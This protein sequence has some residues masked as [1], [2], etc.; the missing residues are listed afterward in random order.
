[1]EALKDSKD[2]ADLPEI[3]RQ[4][5]DLRRQWKAVSV[6]P[7]DDA[8]TLWNR[9]KSAGDEVQ[10]RVDTHLSAVL[11]EQNA[12]LAK[13]L[14]LCEKAEALDAVDRLD[15]D[16]RDAEGAAGRVERDRAGAESAG[17]E[18]SVARRRAPLPHRVRHVLH[19]PQD[20]PRAA[21]ERVGAESAEER[22][23]LRAHGSAR[24]V[25][26]VG[27]DVQRDQ[28]APGRMEDGRS[29]AAQQVGSVVEAVP[30]RV[31]Q[32]LRALRQASRDRSAVARGGAGGDLPL[33]RS[34]RAR[35]AGCRC[36]AVTAGAGS[37]GGGVGAAADR[38]AGRGRVAGVGDAG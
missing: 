37:T 28:A 12:N 31:R 25:H 11:A 7:K 19:A 34:A 26:R 20:R 15:R 33:A 8:D 18:G 35:R 32:V 30:R 14:E 13:K 10:A 6:A 24:R 16:R 38:C 22:N 29:G 2:G 21:Q 3:A 9:F 17:A 1:M 4:L 36:R 23:A 27:R 5:R